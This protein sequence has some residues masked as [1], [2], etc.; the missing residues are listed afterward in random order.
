MGIQLCVGKRSV[1]V[2][3]V[4]KLC[5]SYGTKE[6]LKDISFEIKAGEVFGLLG[7]N[8]MG[9]T[10][11]IKILTGLTHQKSGSALIGGMSV[12]E[13]PLE[14][15]RL[16]RTLTQENTLDR[17]LSVEENLYI[18]AMLYGIDSPSLIIND[19]LNKM[20]LSTY[21]KKLPSKLSGGQQRRLMLA[22]TMMDDPKVLFLD[23]PSLG[24]DP[25]IRR[26]M[27]ENI[28][29]IK[30]KGSAILLTT[31]YIEE[32]EQLCDRVGILYQGRIMALDTPLALIHALGEWSCV[33]FDEM[34]K[35][36]INH[37]FSHQEAQEI[38]QRQKGEVIVRK[39]T[40]ED[41]FL[42]L[43]GRAIA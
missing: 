12:M 34:G 21:A 15:K 43:T 26:L 7:P 10:T 32:A 14:V 31:H 11:T 28:R 23:E 29:E 16:F 39:T 30:A 22:R 37:V 25:Q 38:A 27:W 19:I 24:L 13:S 6:V 9:K 2:I 20:E 17:D 40:L 42:N 5:H 4:E 36:S 41:V 8:G 18:W 1:L 3:K 33:W 35:E